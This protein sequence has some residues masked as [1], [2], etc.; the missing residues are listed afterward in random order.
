[1][2]PPPRSLPAAAL[3]AFAAACT[4]ALA[5]A[6]AQ[7]QPDQSQPGAPATCNPAPAAGTVAAALCSDPAARASDRRRAGAYE[8]LRHQLHPAQRPG[9]EADARA[10]QAFLET[11]CRPGGTAD[12]ACIA[13]AT[14]AKREDLLRWLQPPA[15]EEAERDPDAQAALESRLP[16]APEARREVIATLQRGAGLPATGFL[17]ART[18]ALVLPPA[19]QPTGA[20]PTQPPP[21]EPP[22]APPPDTVWLPRFPAALNA[23]YAVSDCGAPT[24]TWIGGGL[25]FGNRPVSGETRYAIF[26]D[27]QRF[28]LFPAGGGPARILEGQTDGS[29]RLSGT[30]PP[31]LAS[32]GVT[33]GTVLRRCAEQPV[34]IEV[35]PRPRRR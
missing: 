21:A 13:R 11:Q 16:A 23:R 1:M 15:R 33:P 4:P 28:Y 30:I 25:Y 7:P 6:P 8:A 10:F 18:A 5:Q 12:A 34:R 31:A 14:A 29:M 17:D 2:I 19:P 3:V 35:A 24:A 9:L 22:T 32:R 26:A 20:P 27:E